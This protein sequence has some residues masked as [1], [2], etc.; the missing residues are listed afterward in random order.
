MSDTKETS[1]IWE[2]DNNILGS[3]LKTAKSIPEISEYLSTEIIYLKE[4]IKKESSIID[5]GC[6]DGRHLRSL[7]RIISS[8]LGIDMNSEYLNVAINKSRTKKLKFV[9]GNIEKFSPKEYFDYSMSMYN[10]LGV[11]RNQEGL[12]KSMVSSTKAGGILMLSLYSSESI[13]YRMSMYKS[14]GFKKPMLKG[15]TIQIE[16][17]LFSRHYS[18]SDI[19]KL[20]PNSDIVRCS[21]I[22][23]FVKHRI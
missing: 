16:N 5:F 11:V 23:W 14:M 2:N 3:L 4:N 9:K 18:K 10:T 19:M 6:G 15:S 8:G 1:T 21:N 17:G 13:P 22:G 12:I 20:L 7:D